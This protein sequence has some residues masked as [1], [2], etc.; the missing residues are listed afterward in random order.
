MAN[1][2]LFQSSVFLG[3]LHLLMIQKRSFLSTVYTV[4]VF[5]SIWNH[6]TTLWVAKWLDRGWMTVGTVAD[7]AFVGA[8]PFWPRIFGYCL[9]ANYV[10]SFFAAKYM[11]RS[12]NVPHLAAHVGATLCHA[13][14]LLL[15]Q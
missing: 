1:P 8:L 13:W 11:V 3:L 15:V 7:L 14:I 5:T 6:G 12:T 4:G 2:V 10:A 9:V